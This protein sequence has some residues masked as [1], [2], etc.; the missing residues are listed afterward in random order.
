[1]A[2][3]G[4]KTWKIDYWKNSSQKQ[5]WVASLLLYAE[6]RLNRVNGYKYLLMLRRVMQRE[7]VYCPI[8]SFT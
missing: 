5:R 8:N 7:L 4:Q 6:Q 3:V 2:M 1:M